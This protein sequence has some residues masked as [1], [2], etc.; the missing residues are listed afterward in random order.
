M[1]L[2]FLTS[3]GPSSKYK[4]TSGQC[5]SFGL[6]PWERL[7]KKK[8]IQPSFGVIKW[9]GLR[10]KFVYFPARGK[11]RYSLGNT[12]F[13][14]QLR[15]RGGFHNRKKLYEGSESSRQDDNT[16][17]L[18]SLGLLSRE[19]MVCSECPRCWQKCSDWHLRE[20]L[21]WRIFGDLWFLPRS[22]AKNSCNCGWVA[23]ELAGL[24]MLACSLKK[25]ND[26]TSKSWQWKQRNKLRIF[27]TNFITFVKIRKKE[28][29]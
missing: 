1:L 3:A 8:F 5:L 10:R 14:T 9:S 22:A 19:E 23:G 17:K 18:L 24:S 13:W 27:N 20:A 29:T 4:V 2:L 6:R 12:D 7:R 11:D 26:K 28:K 25:I 21:C 15:W 16:V